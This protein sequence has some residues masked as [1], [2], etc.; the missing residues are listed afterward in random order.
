MKAESETELKAIPWER[1]NAVVHLKKS[2]ECTVDRYNAIQV[3]NKELCNSIHVA[4]AFEGFKGVWKRSNP[5]DDK[6]PYINFTHRT[7]RIMIDK[8]HKCNDSLEKKLPKEFLDIVSICLLSH[9]LRFII[10]STYASDLSSLAKETIASSPEKFTATVC[11]LVFLLLTYAWVLEQPDNKYSKTPLMAPVVVSDLSYETKDESTNHTCPIAYII[12]RLMNSNEKS[13]VEFASITNVLDQLKARCSSYNCHGVSSLLE[14]QSHSWWAGDAN[15]VIPSLKLT[16]TTLL[17]V[18]HQVG[19]WSLGTMGFKT[20][21]AFIL[22][23]TSF[24]HAEIPS[25]NLPVITETSFLL[26]SYSYVSTYIHGAL[27]YELNVINT[28]TPKKK[29]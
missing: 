24:K 11:E 8:L 4:A 5:E 2:D 20:H 12:K 21:P 28:I 27:L 13:I 16:T 18:E 6:A 23:E 3:Q 10:W 9:R 1:K 15:I 22:L 19:D 17:D 29:P 14:I 25:L 26:G 7:I